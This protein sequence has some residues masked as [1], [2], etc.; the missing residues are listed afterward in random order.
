MAKPSMKH[1]TADKAVLQYIAGTLSCGIT[2]RQT[3]TTVG[4]CSDADYTGDY[5]GDSDTRRSTTGCVFITNGG[6]IGWSSRL[7]P[8]SS[9]TEA[10]YTASVQAVREALRLRK[11]LGDFGVKV[12]TMPIY[13]HSSSY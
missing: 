7:K 5:A 12:E 13:T 9:T 10:E 1:W 3:N 8:T 4:G 2:L 6:A 11:L